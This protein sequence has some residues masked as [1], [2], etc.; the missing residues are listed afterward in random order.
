MIGGWNMVSLPLTVADRRKTTVFPTSSSDAFT[1]TPSGYT[2][3]DTLRYGEGY[4]LKFP[5]AQTVSIV[6]EARD[7][8]TIDV[9]SGWNMIGSISGPVPTDSIIQIPSAIVISPYF[10]GTPTGYVV[11]DTVHSMRGYW[12]KVSQNGQLIL[13]DPAGPGPAGGPKGNR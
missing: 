12:V 1:Y 10:G 9:V 7:R 3:R 4:W 11:E 8:D 13:V 5:S 6:G 2:A